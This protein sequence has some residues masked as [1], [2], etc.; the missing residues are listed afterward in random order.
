[1]NRVTLIGRTETRTARR[2]VLAADGVDV[3]VECARPPEQGERVAVEGALRS[4]DGSLYVEAI[5]LDVLPRHM[6]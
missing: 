3:P 6:L 5:A 2:F 1:M 4:R